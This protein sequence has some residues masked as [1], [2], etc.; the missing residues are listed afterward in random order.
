MQVQN[1][2]L[3]PLTMPQIPGTQREPHVAFLI[4]PF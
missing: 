1:Y 3:P 4:L 2:S